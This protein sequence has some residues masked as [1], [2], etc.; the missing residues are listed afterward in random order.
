MNACR[1]H[2]LQIIHASTPPVIIDVYVQKVTIEVAVIAQVS[3]SITCLDYYR[4]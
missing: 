4:F 3:E 2:V 1:L